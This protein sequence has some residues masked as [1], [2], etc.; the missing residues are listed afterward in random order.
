MSLIDDVK[1]HLRITS[2][3]YNA[4]IQALIT[5]AIADMKRMG[6]RSEVIGTEDDIENPLVKQAVIL[7]CKAGFGYD[8]PEAPR[9]REMYRDIVISLFN[10]SA[11]EAMYH[12]EQKIDCALRSTDEGVEVR[13]VE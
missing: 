12:T 11:S 9:F 8:N 10:S 4:E 5:S 3:M 13:E 2:D 1:V 7:W 6:L